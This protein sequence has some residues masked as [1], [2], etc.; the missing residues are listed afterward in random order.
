L[1]KFKC[2]KTTSGR[3]KA[4][5]IKRAYQHSFNG[6]VALV[7]VVMTVAVVYGSSCS[8]FLDF[9]ISVTTVEVTKAALVTTNVLRQQLYQLEGFWLQF[10][11]LKWL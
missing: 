6:S 11:R 2:N 10:L 1:P 5:V 7:L 9:N 8:E 4:T 3:I